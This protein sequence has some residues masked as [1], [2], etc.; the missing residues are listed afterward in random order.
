M[1]FLSLAI[2]YGSKDHG[3]LSVHIY[4]KFSFDN[5]DH[6]RLAYVV[7]N[8]AQVFSLKSRL[9]YASKKVI[10]LQSYAV[11]VSRV[12]FIYNKFGWKNYWFIGSWLHMLESNFWGS[13]V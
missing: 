8:H 11:S 9:L 7:I 6:L 4:F 2:Y 5:V 3:S 13:K 12:L 10:Y 1:L